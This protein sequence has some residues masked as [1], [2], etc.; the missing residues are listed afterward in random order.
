M[1]ASCH[2]GWQI[3]ADRKQGIS[4]VALLTATSSFCKKHISQQEEGAVWR[5]S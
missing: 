3:V 5:K 4:G 2:R 1:E